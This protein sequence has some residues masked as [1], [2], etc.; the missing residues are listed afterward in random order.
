M[1]RFRMAGGP[2]PDE[3]RTAGDGVRA[4]FRRL[5]SAGHGLTATDAGWKG[6]AT[7]DELRTAG[8][9]LGPT[10]WCVWSGGTV[11]DCRSRN[12]PAQTG[13]AT[14]PPPNKRMQLTKLRA[15]PVLQAEV[16]P[17]APAGGMDGGTASQLIRGVRRTGPSRGCTASE[18]RAVHRLT[19]Y[20]LTATESG[21]G[22]AG[23]ESPTTDR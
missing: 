16:P 13:V 19:S 21:R 5:R 1:Y 9:I 4:A 11:A 22:L 18:R 23:Y 6:Q 14:R 20:G 3:L 15:A 2:P 7:L 8:H 12:E 17:C 10:R